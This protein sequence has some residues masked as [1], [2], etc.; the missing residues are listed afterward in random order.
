MRNEPRSLQPPLINYLFDPA[1][2]GISI[3]L[4]CVGVSG[5]QAPMRA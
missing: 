5:G 4:Q 1:P 2:H 3:P